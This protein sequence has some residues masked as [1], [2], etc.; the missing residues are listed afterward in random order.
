MKILFVAHSAYRAGAQ[1]LLLKFLMYIKN[2][3]KEIKYDIILVDDGELVGEYKKLSSTFL[4]N[5]DKLFKKYPLLEKIRKFIILRIIKGNKYDL[6]YSNTIMNGDILSKLKI[7]GV[8]VISHIHEMHYWMDRAGDRNLEKVVRYST[9]YICASKAVKDILVRRLKIPKNKIEVIYEFTEEPANIDLNVSIKSKLGLA[10]DVRL[11]G[12][13]GAEEFR[14]GK[15]LFIKIA[16]EYF[17]ETSNFN[18]H[19]IWIGGVL[20]DTIMEMYLS[21]PFKENIHF[22]GHVPNADS[23]FHEFDLFCMTSRDD[24]FPTVNLEAGIRKVPVICFDESGGT[25]ELL[26]KIPDNIIKDWS[27]AAFN[28]RIQVLLQNN[29]LREKIADELYVEI[30]NKYTTEIIANKIIKNIKKELIL[31]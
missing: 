22:V 16:N 2:H 31:M 4:W 3:H 24:P 10:N 20:S 27:I 15:D 8:P 6:I 9:S 26:E 17:Y 21:S 12:A 23:F 25:A 7:K 28:R 29:D 18:T 13:S 1:L 5:N 30:K 11:V 19:F 14:K